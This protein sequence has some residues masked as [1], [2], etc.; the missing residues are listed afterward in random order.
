MNGKLRA[1]IPLVVILIALAGFV[2]T[3]SWQQQRDLKGIKKEV[4]KTK[5]D[6]VS[7]IAAQGEQLALRE[8]SIRTL[9]KDLV[10]QE[11]KLKAFKEIIQLERNEN[12]KERLEVKKRAK[13]FAGEISK[14]KEE[15]KKSL[16]QIQ[17]LEA[18]LKEMQSRQMDV[19]RQINGLQLSISEQERQILII[20]EEFLVRKDVEMNALDVSSSEVSA[21]AET[22]SPLPVEDL[23]SGEIYP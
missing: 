7:Q 9:S 5:K 2:V 10:E 6:L 18:W 16:E 3:S 8:V 21:T 22:W 23:S 19:D 14:Q 17:S 15:V 20:R 4:E 13:V 1:M 12:K 11:R